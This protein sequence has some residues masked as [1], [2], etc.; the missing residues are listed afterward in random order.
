MSK[1][2]D[3]TAA[4]NGK[5][6]VTNQGHPV[7]I[8]CTDRDFTDIHGTCCPIVALIDKG[9]GQGET[10]VSFS[11]DGKCSHSRDMYLV[12]ETKVVTVFTNMWWGNNNLPVVSSS[13]SRSNA[14][15]QLKGLKEDGAVMLMECEEFTREIY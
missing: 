11:I 7:R 10:L 4:L 8:I 1:P 3:L 12:M 6:V 9:M 5:K 2:F 13:A 14:Y 15:N